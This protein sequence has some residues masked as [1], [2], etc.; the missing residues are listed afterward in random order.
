MPYPG[1]PGQNGIANSRL[2]KSTDPARNEKQ[3]YPSIPP[4]TSHSRTFRSR[5]Y[6]CPSA[7][8]PKILRR[9]PRRDLGSLLLTF[10]TSLEFRRSVICKPNPIGICYACSYAVFSKTF[11]DR[12][13]QNSRNPLTEFG[14]SIRERK[15]TV[16]LMIGA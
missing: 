13:L 4:G 6:Y 5:S 2:R 7:Q 15:T 14:V 3:R 16:P 11:A 8:S 9:E 12:N 1:G 10:H